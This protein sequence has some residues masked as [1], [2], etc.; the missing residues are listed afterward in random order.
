VAVVVV[1][2]AWPCAFVFFAVLVAVAL[3]ARL[4]V[5]VGVLVAVLV[6]DALACPVF[7]GVEAF[8]VFTALFVVALFEETDGVFF[9]AMPFSLLAQDSGAP[10]FLRRTQERAYGCSEN[11]QRV[12]KDNEREDVGISLSKK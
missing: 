1:V 7:L 3:A 6:E 10:V 5:L 2:G 4:T 12:A 11:K 9:V 8:E